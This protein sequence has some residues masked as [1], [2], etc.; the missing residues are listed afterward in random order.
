MELNQQILSDLIVYMKYS[1][2]LP[3]LK[4]RETWPEIC[5][6][7]ESMMIEKYPALKTDIEYWMQFVHQKKSVALD[8][9]H[10]VCRNR[11]RPQQQP[12]L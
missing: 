4:R 11:H 5:G 12:Y 6:R 7:Y 1:R 2:Y 3:E 8:A 10:A 9:C